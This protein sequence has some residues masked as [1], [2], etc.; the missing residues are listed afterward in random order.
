MPS[1]ERP[2]N[3]P[4][5]AKKPEQVISDAPASMNFRLLYKGVEIQFTQRDL[6]IKLAPYLEQA[7]KAIDY[8]LTQGFE[9]PPARNWGG[10]KK[11]KI[12]EYVE[13]RTCP[14]DGGKL[15]WKT[16]KDGRRFISCENQRYNFQTKQ[17]E[18]CKFTEWPPKEDK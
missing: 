10:Q 16:T 8:A 15:I 6:D 12:V 4:E 7:K 1:P 11:E 17:V 2:M 18:G 9:A 3:N 5:P 13:G 14:T